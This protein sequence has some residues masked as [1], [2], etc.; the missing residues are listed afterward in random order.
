MIT[1]KKTIGSIGVIIICFSA[2]FLETLFISY[3]LDLNKLDFSHFTPP[4]AEF[5][6]AQ[7]AMCTMMNMIS[8]GILELFSFVLLF[9]S[10]A[11]YIEENRS[12]M[13]LLKALGYTA[14]Q[15]GAGM[16]KFALP[17]FVGSLSGYLGALGF[18]NP[19]Y[20]TMNADGIIPEF[21]FSFNP[22]VFLGIVFGPALL[23]LLFSYM[24][25]L[26]KAKGNP[27]KMINQTEKIKKGKKAQETGKFIHELQRTVLKNHLGLIIF[28]GFS[29]ICFSSCIQM[30]FTMYHETDTSPMFFWM[31][32]TIGMLLGVT[33]IFL[34]FRFV[35]KGNLRYL[36]ILKAY[37]YK[38]RECYQAMYGGY[39]LV[40][41]IAFAIGTGYQILLLSTMFKKFAGTYGIAY[42]FDYL[43]FFY[44]VVLFLI[45]YFITNLFYYQKINLLKIEE[46]NTD[47]G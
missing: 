28:V 25:G 19:F 30:S 26:W 17:T 35:F 1:F 16:M 11:R 44:S 18:A 15:I 23:V 5:F 7:D 34:A 47:L 4:Q 20:D 3:K 9:F 13:G 27:M 12:N 45:V 33:I 37:G 8:L 31:M 21:S 2:M 43:G 24:V 38:N 29:V 42:K 41:T 6:R 22:W 40:S 14:N 39:H 36:S 46:L 32:L 10:V